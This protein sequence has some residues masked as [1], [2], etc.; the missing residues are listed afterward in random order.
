MTI[1]CTLTPRK[2]YFRCRLVTIPALNFEG[3]GFELRP[4][5]RLE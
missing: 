2:T 3:P 5:D 4:W 1:Y